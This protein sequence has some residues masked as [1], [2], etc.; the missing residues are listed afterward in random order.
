MMLI[1]GGE[2]VEMVDVGA[3]L[4]EVAGKAEGRIVGGDNESGGNEDGRTPDA[5]GI[6]KAIIL[7]ME[8]LVL[9]PKT[10]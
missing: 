9:G 10:P 6:F 5:G 4:V 2:F 8:L 1:L 7:L 3:I